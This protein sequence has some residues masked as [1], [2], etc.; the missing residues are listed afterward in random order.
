MKPAQLQELLEYELQ[1]R[2][3]VIWSAQPDPDEFV[4]QIL[5]FATI[6]LTG[7]F[8]LSIGILIDSPGEE[9]N[10]LPLL[11]FM[12]LFVAGVGIV[13]LIFVPMKAR[14]SLYALTDRRVIS[15]H[16]RSK[17]GPNAHMHS[18]GKT[19][20]SQS[21]STPMRFYLTHMPAQIVFVVL[22]WDVLR[23][24]SVE[25]NMYIACGYFL[26][27]VGWFYQWYTD[28][29]IPSAWFR[30]PGK[31]LYTVDGYTVC[32]EQMPREN[33]KNVHMRRKGKELADIFVISLK[34]GCLRF[35]NSRRAEEAK[36]AFAST[37]DTT[38]VAGQLDSER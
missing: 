37:P 38:E 22:S 25:F 35:K 34:D 2:E 30:E 21:S 8:L 31:Q 18:L 29:R 13:E 10:L 32:V 26:I 24:L 5:P 23:S 36:T 14:D 15:L 4:N 3:R 16:V 12:L 1:S 33:I 17:P 9:Q 20:I 11:I 27:A 19:L 6:W 28:I 7:L